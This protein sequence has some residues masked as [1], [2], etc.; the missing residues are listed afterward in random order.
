MGK[1]HIVRYVLLF[2]LF[3]FAIPILTLSNED[4]QAKADTNVAVQWGY[5][6]IANTTEKNLQ[7]A[8][9][10]IL[11]DM[12]PETYYH[13]DAYWDQ[14][15]GTNLYGSLDWCQEYA[16]WGTNFWVGDFYPSFI[17][18][19][20]GSTLHHYFYGY[21]SDDILD[22]GVMQ[23]A[24][25]QVSSNQY[26]NFIW[27]CAC[28]GCYWDP[29]YVPGDSLYGYNDFDN[30]TGTVGMPFGFTGTDGM[31]ID[32][33]NQPDNGPYCYIGWQNTSWNIGTY[34]NSTNPYY[35][36]FAFFIYFVY[37]SLLNG[38]N[39]SI[40]DSLDYA[41]DLMWQCD[42]GDSTL[43]TGYTSGEYCCHL[44]VLGNTNISFP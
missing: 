17:T 20:Y 39:P 43:V 3:S 30:F 24:N 13:Q 10:D 4:N 25:Y 12:Y 44:C 1:M 37:E 28:G 8:L 41:S 9:C 38:V 19:Q 11:N 40:A 36:N 32:G 34:A 7:D 14:T 35:T 21:N 16:D 5:M 6:T 23:H 27:T 42:Y 29:G 33:Y 31:S 22:Y 15:T 2:L 18:S 26:F